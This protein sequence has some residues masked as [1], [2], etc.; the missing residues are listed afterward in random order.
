VGSPSEDMEPSSPADAA[1]LDAAPLDAALP[2]ASRLGATRARIDRLRGRL[3]Q[4]AIRRRLVGA[5]RVVVDSLH[6]PGRVL[7]LVLLL[8]FV[9]RIIWLNLPSNSLIFDEQYYV[10]AARVLL[11]WPAT[12]H[13][14]SS[15]PGFDPN[16]EHPPLGKLLIAGSMLLFGDNGIG[17]RVPS[18]VAAMIAL[19]AVYQIVR[20]TSRS[21]W[22]AVLVVALVSLDNLTLVHGR[23]G[24]LDMLVLAP[25]LVAAWLALRRRWVLAGV[26]LGIAL[27]I[28]VTAIYAVGAIVLYVLLTDGPAWWK[29]RRV[30]WL[31]LLAPLGFLLVTFSIAIGGL[32][33]LDAR[34]TKFTTPIDHI[35]RIVSYGTNLRAPATSGVCPEADSR[36]WDWIFNECQITYLRRDVTVRQGETVVSKHATVDFRGAFNPLLAAA[37]PFVGLFCVWYAWRTRSRLA[38]WAVAWAAANYLPYVALAIFTPRI[39]YIYYALPLVP[40]VAIMIALFL[41]RLRLPSF[42]RWGFLVAYVIGFIAYFPFRQVP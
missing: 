41:T 3:S 18:V 1:P 37:V 27:L 6:D 26:A 2:T 21:I 35:V 16:T 19:A 17:W 12:T 24:T 33:V 42:V 34:Y 22:L 31:D 4:S 13:Y 15:P 36:P 40:A 30:P 20:A 32:A 23:I 11:G 39:E 5:G 8:A 10:N 28:K 7:A 38:I 14:A 29:A 9:L 25:M